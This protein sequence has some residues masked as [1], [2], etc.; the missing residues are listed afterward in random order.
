MPLVASRL[1]LKT[2]AEVPPW[3]ADLYSSRQAVRRLSD[4][5]VDIPE[6]KY[7]GHS[8]LR[9]RRARTKWAS[10]FT[11]GPDRDDEE[12]M[13][14]CAMWLFGTSKEAADLRNSQSEL[15]G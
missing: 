9:A 10:K 13:V 3:F 6:A 11:A 12:C 8:H 2:P 5:I 4:A 15:A 7:A 14:R 1:G